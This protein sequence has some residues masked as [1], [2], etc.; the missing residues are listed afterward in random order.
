MDS[1]FTRSPL[2]KTGR[3]MWNAC[4]EHNS[5]EKAREICRE[6]IVARNEDTVKLADEITFCVELLA[7][8]SEEG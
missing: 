8:M 2:Y 7:A 1:P 4:L 5:R 3:D 6:Y